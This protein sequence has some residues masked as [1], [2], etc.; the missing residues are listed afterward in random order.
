[1]KGEEPMNPRAKRD[2]LL[3]EE[4][5]DE[6]IVYDGGRNRGHCLNRT[7]AFV[8]RHADGEHSIAD[9]AAM[10]RTELDPV[11]DENLVW[12]ALDQLNAAQLLEEPPPRSADQ[13]RASRRQFISKVGLVGI[14][15]LLLP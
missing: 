12:H 7:A 10:L 8:W 9:L 1:M 4:L 5:E 3:S 2:G 6:L 13:M 11:V 15:T 14:A